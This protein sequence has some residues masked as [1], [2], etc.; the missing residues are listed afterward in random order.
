[1]NEVE[2]LLD[3]ARALVSEADAAW[4]AIAASLLALL[5]LG[6]WLRA[7]ARAGGGDAEL[8]RQ[9]R[10][11]QNQISLLKGD[12]IQAKRER[13]TEVDALTKELETLRAVA[14]GQVPPELGQWKQR[15]LKAE[16]RLESDR[17][18]HRAEI[19][20]VLSAV[21]T[22]G[23]VDQTMIA[24]GGARE[25]VERLE[26]ELAAARQEL[27][28]ATKSYESEI[29]ALAERLNAEKAAALTA[30]AR[31]H[32]AELEALQHRH[33]AAMEGIEPEHAVAEAVPM[34]GEPDLADSARFPF[35]QGVAGAGRGSRFYLPYDVATI[36]RSD[37]NTVVLQESM[38]SRVHAEIRFD[39][40]DFTVTD[41][42]STNGTT[43]ND[44]LLT[45]A[46]LAFGD[47]IGIGETRLRFTCE[48]S[49][50]AARDPAFAEAAFRAMLRLAPKCRPVLRGLADLLE[51]NGQRSEEAGV[52][53]AKLQ[54]LEGTTSSS[55]RSWD[56]PERTP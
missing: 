19:E 43:L 15:A 38:A 8:R 45:S 48:A 31:R 32:A 34:P 3:Q 12:A 41:R 47:L 26:Q 50:A 54:E 6:L 10:A 49:E 7:R 25:R 23:S 37:S 4:L 5:F 16:Q 13:A 36:G 51:Q 27:E 55:Q 1:M 14:A 11:A 40:A 30:Q 29:A 2:R 46:R 22:S 18:R 42:N 33:P 24:P 53:E 17:E 44:E 21:G 56:L 20:K 28:A 35:L 9:L 52:L 39:G